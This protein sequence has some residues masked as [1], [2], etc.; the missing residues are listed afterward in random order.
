MA[1]KEKKPR[2]R[3]KVTI[4]NIVREERTFAASEW[5]AV[6]NVLARKGYKGRKIAAAIT[7]LKE[8]A[9][10]GRRRHLVVPDPVLPKDEPFKEVQGTLFD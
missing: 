2:K 8:D 4:R 10:R 5:D 3:Y 7:E 1:K 9:L 6:G